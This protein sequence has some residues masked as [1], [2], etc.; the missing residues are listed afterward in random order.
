MLEIALLAGLPWRLGRLERVAARGHDGRDPVSESLPDV[1]EHPFASLILG[2][3]VQERRDRLVL[4]TTVLDHERADTEQVPDVGDAASL[5]HLR[6][7]SRRREP[8]C[9]L[10]A[11]AEHNRTGDVPVEIWAQ[12]ATLTG[13]AAASTAERRRRR[14]RD[15][16][17]LP[18]HAHEH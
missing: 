5:S 14:S 6:A 10:E 1:G 16:R 11:L 2:R 12:G 8:Q 18:S 9:L 4:V 15:V 3:V 17:P 7:M 13:A